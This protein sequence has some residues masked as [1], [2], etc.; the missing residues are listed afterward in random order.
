MIL[1]GVTVGIQATV[2]LFDVVPQAT[3]AL[4]EFVPDTE[5]RCVQHGRGGTLV[6]VV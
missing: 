2:A 4:K 5:R 1:F 3:E 6:L